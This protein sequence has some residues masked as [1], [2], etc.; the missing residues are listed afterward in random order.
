MSLLEISACGTVLILVG[1]LLRLRL[2]KDACM[3]VWWGAVLRLLIPVP[4]PAPWSV[5]SFLKALAVKPEPVPAGP[6]VMVL[7]P[8][9]APPVLPDAAP[10]ENLAPIPFR[11][12]LWIEIGRAHV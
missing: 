10:V 6:P 9:A 3:V 7:T 5:Y 2:P 1:M 8:A 4:L 12:V 11:T